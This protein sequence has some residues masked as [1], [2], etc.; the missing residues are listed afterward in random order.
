M[1]TIFFTRFLLIAAL[2]IFPISCKKNNVN[3]NDTPTVSNHTADLSTKVNSSVSGF[4][5]DETNAPVFAAL[6]KLGT[7]TTHT[8]KYGHFEIKNV[9]VI[10]EAAVVTV[11]QP[12]YFKGIKTY[13]ATPDKEVFFRIKLLPKTIAGTINANAGGTV[14]TATGLNIGFPANAIKDASTGIS[15]TGSV[16]VAVQYIDPT[17]DELNKVMPGDLRGININNY[18]KVLRSFGMTAVE[19]T[20]SGGELLQIVDG[21][22]ATLTMPVPA[23]IVSNAPST[24]PLWYFDE[25]NG[26]WREDG[27]AT[28]T[29]NNYVG[30][31][32]HFSFWNCDLPASYVEF[33]CT[34]VD[35]AGQPIPY[36]C[37]RI[38]VL[39]S[40]QTGLNGTSRQDYTNYT[41][42]VSGVIPDNSQLRLEVFSTTNYCVGN[43][44]YSYDFTT[45]NVNVSLGVISITLGVA[46]QVGININGTVTN[47]NNLPVQNGFIILNGSGNIYNYPI[48][49]GTY[50]INMLT[51]ASD[52]SITVT[53]IAQDNDS[54]QQSDPV[55]MPVSVGTNTI[56]PLQACGVQIELVISSGYVYHPSAP[57]ALINFQKNFEFISPN[58]VVCG[59]GDLGATG[60]FA[61]LETEILTNHITISAMPGAAGGPY[62]QWDAGLP[63][64]SPGPMYTP[65][66][67]SSAQCNNTYNPT[68]NTYY[69]RYGYIGGT[70]YRV[71]EEI[72]QRF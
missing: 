47:C 1:K 66:W 39:N 46:A 42:Y 14:S 65:Q 51:C 34:I 2:F 41:G 37:V 50:N 19:L 15:Y 32:S 59:M 11:E 45:T 69:L 68:T 22:K 26:L 29:G 36:T 18:I 53:L 44:V 31:V 21:K 30:D 9:Q 7:A 71:V 40:N 10:K 49:N 55:I 13:I 56:P 72:I 48:I 58:A 70:G 52:P 3:N 16:N 57:R 17:S 33:N 27:T 61:I 8:N 38:T 24:I 43:A 60:Y 4:V 12:G 23:G 20:G 28:R 5:T 62:F 25:A 63:T 54:M 35:P 6:V 64:S 67:S